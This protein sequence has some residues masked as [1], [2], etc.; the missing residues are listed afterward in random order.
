MHISQSASFK[1]KHAGAGARYCRQSFLA[2]TRHLRESSLPHCDKIQNQSQ[3]CGCSFMCVP[4]AGLAGGGDCRGSEAWQG[5]PAAAG[6]GTTLAMSE[7]RTISNRHQH[8]YEARMMHKTTHLHS[9][10]LFFSLHH[11][12]RLTAC[13]D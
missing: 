3:W 7:H 6:T 12:V 5:G 11:T 4:A 10:C 13:F 1:S 9:I 2:E 8:S